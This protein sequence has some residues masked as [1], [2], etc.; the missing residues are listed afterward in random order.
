MVRHGW[1]KKDDAFEVCAHGACEIPREKPS[2]A[3]V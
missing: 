1:A 3:H 2:P